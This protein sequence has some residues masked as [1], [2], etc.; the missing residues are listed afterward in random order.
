MPGD[1][2]ARVA[3]ARL[4]PVPERPALELTSSAGDSRPLI[5]VADLHLG[6]GAPPGSAMGPPGAL[7]RGMALDLLG[8]LHER[9]A[10]GLLI[11]GDVKHP[12]VGTPPALRPVVFDFFSTFLADGLAVEIVLG[13]HDVGLARWL[14]KEVVV[15]PA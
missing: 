15:H 2:P 8:L 5:A 6:L 14:P 13:N 9:S 7:A 4:S 3:E 12:I 1:P 11:V 10:S